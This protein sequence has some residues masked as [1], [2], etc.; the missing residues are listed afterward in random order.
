MNN[1][2]ET[3][4]GNLIIVGI[5]V[6]TTTQDGKAMTDIG[7]LFNQFFSQNIIEKIENKLSNDVYCVYTDYE[8]DYMGEYT[9]YIGCS[10]SSTN[11]QSNFAN[12]HIPKSKYRK[13]TS[14]GNI[15]GVVGKTW[16][17]IWSDNSIP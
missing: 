15:H 16:N 2:T 3:L 12:K 4:L 5:S 17:E 11:D 1:Y 7:N 6:R 14:K 8:S 9:V 13:Y 10:V